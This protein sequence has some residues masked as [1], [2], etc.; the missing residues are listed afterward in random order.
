MPDLIDSERTL[1]HVQIRCDHG[2]CG[3]KYTIY[4]QVPTHAGRD[5]VLYILRHA[6]RPVTCG[7]T[8]HVFDTPMIL[9]CAPLVPTPQK[10]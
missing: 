4:T 2:Q 3:T 8:G 7:K 6:K 1:W 5:Y 9:Y 10:K